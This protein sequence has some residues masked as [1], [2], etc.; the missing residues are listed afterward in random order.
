GGDG[1][2]AAVTATYS[3]GNGSNTHV[4]A[5]SRT[6]YGSETVTVSY[7][8]GTVTD[9]AFNALAA[10][11]GTAVTNSSAQDVF[12]PVDLS[13]LVAWYSAPS[14]SVSDGT[15]LGTITDRSGAGHHATQAG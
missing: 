4:Y 7:S 12:S 5:L 11:S 2:G 6:V 9:W 3:S 1:A 15:A 14:E 13:G 8:P 10:F